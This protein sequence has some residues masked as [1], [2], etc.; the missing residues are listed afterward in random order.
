MEVNPKLE[1]FI[2]LMYCRTSEITDIHQA[3][4]RFLAS[5]CSIDRIPPTRGAL[6]Q[7]IKRAILQTKLWMVCL[8]KNPEIPSPLNY[9]W[10]QTEDKT[11]IIL[12]WSEL[13]VV[14]EV[15]RQLVK[16]KCKKTCSGN[17][18]TIHWI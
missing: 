1:R 16:C 11:A 5:G 14:S 7:H 3:R 8:I 15:L 18:N 2:I 13:P 12:K 9:G 6:F 17:A 10:M 4:Y